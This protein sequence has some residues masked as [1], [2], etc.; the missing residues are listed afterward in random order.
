MFFADHCCLLF[1]IKWSKTDT[2]ITWLHGYL[3]FL[4]NYSQTHVMWNDVQVSERW[5]I[6]VRK[7]GGNALSPISLSNTFS[8]KPDIKN[9][10]FSDNILC[11]FIVKWTGW[12][13]V[14][15]NCRS[16]INVFTDC[17]KGGSESFFQTSRRM[18]LSFKWLI[19]WVS[20]SFMSLNSRHR[21]CVIYGY[22]FC[23]YWS[24]MLCAHL[25]VHVPPIHEWRH[26]YARYVYVNPDCKSLFLLHILIRLKCF[27]LI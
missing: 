2:L 13:H 14:E 10:H 11:I 12:G 1:Q 25:Y 26:M 22:L 15:T 20:Q 16:N 23:V 5:A 24:E 18:L 6:H 9:K 4:W 8:T 27:H 21:N 3:N 7:G 19:L 17:N